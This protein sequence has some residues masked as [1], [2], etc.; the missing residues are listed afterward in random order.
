MHVNNNIGYYCILCLSYDTVETQIFIN[1][2]IWPNVFRVNSAMVFI[3]A[4]VF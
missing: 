2:I 4:Q 3:Q 1:E